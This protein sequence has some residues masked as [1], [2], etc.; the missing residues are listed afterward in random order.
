MNRLGS[1]SRRRWLG[2]GGL[3]LWAWSASAPVAAQAGGGRSVS[4]PLVQ[5]WRDGER[6][7]YVST[8]TSD[9]TLARA[10]GI[11]HVPLLRHA[12][13]SPGQGQSLVERVYMFAGGEQI[14]VFPSAPRPVGPG[15][16]D[17]SYSPL[18]R[19]VW[20]RWKNPADVRELR[21]E[22]AVLDAQDKGQLTLE[23][24]DIVINCPVVRDARGQAL[25]G[26]S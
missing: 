1:T 12:L 2:L 8:D 10:K 20:V 24:T 17:A 26:V 11:N 7:D 21:S 19:G 5:A 6:M 16:T 13:R 14:N 25:R 9:A 15:N 18:W 3:W 4:L 22:E 23:L